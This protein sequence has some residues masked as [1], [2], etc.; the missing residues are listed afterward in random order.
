[1]QPNEIGAFH[2]QLRIKTDLQEDPLVVT[3]SGEVR[4]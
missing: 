4:E 3:V 2:R 1:V